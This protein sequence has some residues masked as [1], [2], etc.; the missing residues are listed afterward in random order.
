MQAKVG[1]V[2]K[3]HKR[4]CRDQNPTCGALGFHTAVR[5][6]RRNQI[7]C[8]GFRMF[9]EAEVEPVARGRSGSPSGLTITGTAELSFRTTYFYMQSMRACRTCSRV[10]DYVSLL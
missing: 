9:E 10:I 4:H 1:R 7:L 5:I 8:A 3:F 6:R 2:G